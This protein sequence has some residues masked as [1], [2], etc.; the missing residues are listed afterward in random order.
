[1]A[2]RYLRI[3]V[4]GSIGVL[5]RAIRWKQKN[6]SEVLELLKSIPVKTS[7]FIRPSLLNEIIREVG[8]SSGE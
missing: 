3:P 2:A 8:R 7:L 4:H 6:P 5:I 1:M